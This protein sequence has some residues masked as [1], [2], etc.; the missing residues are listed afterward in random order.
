MKLDGGLY[1]Q[2][3]KHLHPGIDWQRIETGGTGR[4]IPDVNFCYAGVEGWIENKKT[5]KWS[6]NLRPEQVGWIDRRSRCGGRVWIAVRRLHE[7]GVRKGSAGDE[8][9]LIPGRLVIKLHEEGLHKVGI[10]P[11]EGGPSNWDW[12]SVATTIGLPLAP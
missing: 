4:G 7:G 5:S 6:A 1:D 9:W 8:L 10:R 11:Y 2:F 3:K 12:Y